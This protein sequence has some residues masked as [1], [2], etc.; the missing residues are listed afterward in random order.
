ME[1]RSTARYVPISFRKVKLV[2]D[3]IRGEG[4]ERALEILRLN[5]GRAARLVEKVVHAAVAAAAELHDVEAEGL[6]VCRA[7]VD[8]GPLRKGRL[9]RARGSWTPILHRSSHIHIVVSDETG[10]AAPEPEA[11][12]T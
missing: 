4:V 1:T 5:R 11:P 2:L 7:W 9:T 8:V 12:A 3:T 6:V 10:E